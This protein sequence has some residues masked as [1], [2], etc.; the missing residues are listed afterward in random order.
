MMTDSCAGLLRR[1]LQFVETAQDMTLTQTVATAAEATPIGT[2]KLRF[3][4][5]G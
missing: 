3:F 4:D 1:L 5:L 2:K